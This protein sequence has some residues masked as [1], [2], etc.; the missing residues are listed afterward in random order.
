[1][2]H[3][4]FP[5]GARK[6]RHQIA[7]IPSP[8]LSCVNALQHPPKFP[9]PPSNVLED[10]TWKEAGSDATSRPHGSE[11]LGGCNQ[12]QQ[13]PCMADPPRKRRP[14]AK[15][16]NS[17]PHNGPSTGTFTCP[18]PSLNHPGLIVSPPLPPPPQSAAD[19]VCTPGGSPPDEPGI[20]WFGPLSG[21]SYPSGMDNGMAPPDE[22]GPKDPSAKST[23]LPHSPGR[24]TASAETLSCHESVVQ[25]RR[26]D[27]DSCR[28][29]ENEG[30]DHEGKRV[31]GEPNPEEE[32]ELL[33]TSEGPETSQELSIEISSSNPHLEFDPIPTRAS[34]I[35]PHP[36]TP[37]SVAVERA[38]SS[39][40]SGKS[41]PS[42][43]RIYEAGSF[44][45]Q[46][47]PELP[48]DPSLFPGKVAPSIWPHHQAH[49]AAGTEQSASP[50]IC[51]G[52]SA[53][54]RRKKLRNY[55]RTSPEKGKI[56]VLSY[57]DLDSSD[58][59]RVA[60]ESEND[61]YSEVFTDAESGSYNSPGS[62]KSASHTR[63]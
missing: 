24:T 60:N 23:R 12:T 21:P 31:A 39:H 30:I 10:R 18:Q 46:G 3:I 33:A 62:Q 11:K 19:W 29:R 4:F 52:I 15:Q 38:D 35:A 50:N 48:P 34:D 2:K 42:P 41:E 37:P 14:C 22:H 27:R 16:D 61:N 58:E 20:L 6:T 59:E 1:M 47:P 57:P 51:S 26:V 7:A 28:V 63:T 5:R 32:R 53:L 56:P 25:Q 8:M 40:L 55:Q 49:A 54:G 17:T 43:A 44:Q 45:G 36:I 9:L 13:T